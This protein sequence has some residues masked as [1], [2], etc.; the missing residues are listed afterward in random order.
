MRPF[1][2]ATILA[3]TF[4]AT[5]GT[6]TSARA[7]D[8]VVEDVV[9]ESPTGA[10]VEGLLDWTAGTVTVTG[11]GFVNE[12]I[13]HPVQR[14]LLGF[15]AAKVDA[16]RRLLEIIGVVQ[17]D[18]RT[19][20]S[21]AMVASDSTRVHVEGLVRG[22]RVV[23]GSQREEDGYY[24]LDLT[25]GLRG[26]LSAAVLPDSSSAPRM[27]P[28][29][30]PTRDSI[31][32]FIPPKPYTGLVVDARG[33]SLR[34]S[35]SPRILDDS[36]RVIYAASHVDRE[37]AVQTGVVAYDRSLPMAVVSDR[38]GGTSSHPFLVKATGV[39]GLYNSDVV[40]TRDMGT[41]IRMADMDTDFLA[42]CRVV[43]VVG[44]QPPT[45]ATLFS[46]AGSSGSAAHA[47]LP[48]QDFLDSILQ[49]RA[50]DDSASVRATTT[51]ER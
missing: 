42:Q 21:M 49:T 45:P 3:A 46:A 14:R 39:S 26:D 36:G 23:P 13:T 48:T 12:S 20:V 8:A 9:A 19:T 41:R 7:V 10:V 37:Y 38:V 32:V 30:L 33:S 25:L 44:P 16:Y 34:P 29:D 40:V 18:A 28:E 31:V 50:D 5:F 11:E 6:A 24:R 2:L 17:I 15:R 4:G 35:L 27:L 51:V 47:P 22:A 1:T 43:F